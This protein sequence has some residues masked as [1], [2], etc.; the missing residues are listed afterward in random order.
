[1]SS[2]ILQI[3]AALCML[4]ASL[5]VTAAQRTF[6]SGG[7][8]DGNPCTITL[9]CR[10][11]AAAI[12]QTSA[13]GEVIVLDSA[14]Y[15]PVTVTQAVSIIAPPGVYAG[16]TAP[17][18]GVGV[19]VSAGA[20]DAVTIRGLTFSEGTLGTGVSLVTGRMLIV[21]RCAI[22]GM[23]YFFAS[24][25]DPLPNPA[26]PTSTGVLIWSGTFL[27]RDSMIEGADTGVR[28]VF[29]SPGKIIGH[30]EGTTIADAWQ[31]IVMGTNV[32]ITVARSLISGTGTGVGIGGGGFASGPIDVHVSTTSIE[33]FSTAI[34]VGEAYDP[35]R[36]TVVDSDITNNVVALA[37]SGS[38]T[39][40]LSNVRVTHNQNGVDAVASSVYTSGTNY[41]RD[42][43]SDGPAMIGPVGI[44]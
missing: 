1:M 22:H 9:P 14:G 41:F 32:N 36:V 8:V 24:K 16:I 31:G 19:T 44:K 30:I 23:R 6:V 2:R 5:S 25:S 39:V 40:S 34:G 27:I 15:G 13:G 17:S 11:F 26:P 42:N 4:V 3:A 43:M 7:G 10:S 37:S 33:R 20:G 21:D 29:F 18:L 28:A 38:A 12:T 35:A